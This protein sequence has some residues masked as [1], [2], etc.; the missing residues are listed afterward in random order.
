MRGVY[1][2]SRGRGRSPRTRELH[3]S[4]CPR[5]NRSF[6]F[7]LE[8]TK[9][10][11]PAFS[12]D[13]GGLFSQVCV[14]CFFFHR[15]F[16]PLGVIRLLLREQQQPYYSQGGSK[17]R[18]FPF[19]TPAREKNPFITPEGEKTKKNTRGRINPP[20]RTKKRVYIPRYFPGGTKIYYRTVLVY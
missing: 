8:N 5:Y 13:M 7:L 12:F 18:F 17:T 19:F 15:F 1:V 16:A 9:V 4:C 11:T 10:Y 6:L 20:Y 14:F 3:P 2:Y